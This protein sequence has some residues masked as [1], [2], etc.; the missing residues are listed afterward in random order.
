[1]K[2]VFAFLAVMLLLIAGCLTS[3]DDKKDDTNNTNNNGTGGTYSISGSV[4][5]LSATG[6]GLSAVTVT[7]TGP[8]NVKLTAATGTDG[9]Y[10]FGSL[11]DGNYSVSAVKTGY[12]FDQASVAVVVKGSN[13]IATT[14]V[15]TQTSSGTGTTA[16]LYLPYKVGA[17][18]N[19]KSHYA[20][21]TSAYDDTYSERVTGTKVSG[22]KTYL[23]LVTSHTDYSDTTFARIENNIAYSFMENVD[24]S[25]AKAAKPARITKN[26]MTSANLE[27]PM[28]KFGINPGTSYT[29]YTLT[30]NT[31]TVTFTGKYLGLEAVTV[32]AGTFQN[33]AK[34][35]ITTFW[36]N[37]VNKVVSSDTNVA[38]MWFAPNV[39]LVKEED[40]YTYATGGVTSSGSTESI[41][42]VSYSIP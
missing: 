13:C 21:G 4:K 2:K 5:T 17:S 30:Q 25:L 8:N 33:C 16:T 22:G 26:F 10:S 9:S 23:I 34:Y 29:I 18:W 31:A 15:A 6:S 28:F 40:V 37:T 11:A 7:L 20:Y 24:L 35:E 42:L 14:L 12:T 41:S 1:M 32:T 19:Y 39:G 36:Q 3:S 38:S 27:L